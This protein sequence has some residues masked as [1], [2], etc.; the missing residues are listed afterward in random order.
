M[1]EFHDYDPAHPFQVTNE[2]HVIH[3][4]KITLDYVPL[5]SSVEIEGFQ[6]SAAISPQRGEFYI[7][8]GDADN[9]RTADQTVHF[10]DGYDGLM[11]VAHY[12]GVSTILRACHMNEIKAFMETGA[13]ELAAR[14]IAGHEQ[15]IMDAIE[16]HCGHIVS[17]LHEISEAVKEMGW[18]GGFIAS[19]N[20]ADEALDEYFEGDVDETGIPS[21]IA[22][23]SDVE[24][25]L[26]EYFPPKTADAGAV[27]GESSGDG[28]VDDDF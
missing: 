5:K 2:R 22:D 11:V 18:T 3:G 1:I 19:D 27:A 13:S 8:Y 21:I 6:E 26:D 25:L 10:P 16:E 9:Y 17:A 12:Q 7:E 20:E 15:N 4:N 24:Q 23:D 28:D 14:M